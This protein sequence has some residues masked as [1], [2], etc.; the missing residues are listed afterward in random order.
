[1]ETLR[2]SPNYKADDWRRLDKSKLGDWPTAVA[3]VRD[4]LHGRFLK[5]ADQVLP[6]VSS[7]FIVLSIDCLLV[8]TIQQF[9]EGITDGTG[10]AGRLCREFLTG[11]RFQPAFDDAARRAFYL[12]IR[13]G[14]L[15]QAEAKKK[16][17]VRRNVGALLKVVAADEYIIDVRLFHAAV[18][19]SFE[20]YLARIQQPESAD[21]RDK[22]WTKMDHLCNIRESRGAMEIDD[23]SPA[24]IRSADV[25]W[26]CDEAGDPAFLQMAHHEVG[27]AIASRLV[28]VTV[29]VLKVSQRTPMDRFDR[30]SPAAT[31]GCSYCN[32]NQDSF[33]DAS[34]QAKALIK[35]AGYVAERRH[36]E[37]SRRQLSDPLKDNLELQ[38]IFMR[39]AGMGDPRAEGKAEYEYFISVL[40]EKLT[41]WLDRTDVADI[42]DALIDEIKR[43]RTDQGEGHYACAL[44]G[45]AVETITT[46]LSIEPP[47]IITW[48]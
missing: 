10:Q 27:H 37:Q 7:G 31:L 20:D 32:N 6:D 41:A 21:L 17:L 22:L 3:I 29:A 30:L 18:K 2:I 9:I 25:D 12:D 46:R 42:F 36:C 23:A 16:W 19:G 39:H 14:L 11:Q 1:M 15:H 35:R 38:G 34:W 28:G 24:T 33:T 48:P 45:S 40:D 44:D 43:A 8:E 4:R 5:F 47:P 13:C 26:L